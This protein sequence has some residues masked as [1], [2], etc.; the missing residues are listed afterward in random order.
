MGAGP[1]IRKT[2][3]DVGATTACNAMQKHGQ[4]KG[5]PNIMHGQLQCIKLASSD[6]VA[7]ECMAFWI[8]QMQDY[9]WSKPAIKD[10]NKFFVTA[11]YKNS[12][13]Y[14]VCVK[15]GSS[16]RYFVFVLIDPA[17]GPNLKDNVKGYTG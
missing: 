4:I 14:G 3:L 11:V 2:T 5:N 1:L 16:G 9:D 15:R 17:P 8:S 6:K 7:T 10:N 12:T 13:H